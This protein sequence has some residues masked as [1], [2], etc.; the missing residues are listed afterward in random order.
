MAKKKMTE[1]DK[2]IKKEI[3]RLRTIFK[4]ID[5]NKKSTS[6]GLIEEAAFMRVT[7][8]EL[9]KLIDESGP[10]DVMPQ[11]DYSILREHPAVKIYTTMIQ[12]YTA[13]TKQL[14]DLLP[15]ELQKVVD[16]GFDAF[17]S[18]RDE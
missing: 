17:V 15:K 4:D 12:R 11:G 3:E 2:Q 5:E 9:K 8:Q 16:D 10:I 7:L 13:M 14:T 1:K 18:G 6:E